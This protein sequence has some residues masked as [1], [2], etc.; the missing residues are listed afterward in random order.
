MSLTRNPNS[1]Y[2]ALQATPYVSIELIA[3]KEGLFFSKAALVK[4]KPEEIRIR[5]A[6]PGVY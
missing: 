2:P 6:T 5:F 3:N 4:S 1:L